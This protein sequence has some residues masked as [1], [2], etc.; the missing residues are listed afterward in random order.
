MASS[1]AKLIAWTVVALL[2]IANLAMAFPFWLDS[3]TRSNRYDKKCTACLPP[4][5]V[6]SHTDTRTATETKTLTPTHSPVGTLTDTPTTTPTF[7]VSPTFTPTPIA[8]SLVVD[9][10]EGLPA[11]D[12]T[13]DNWGYPVAMTCSAGLGSS[14]LAQPSGTSAWVAN[15]ADT[16]GSFG[17]SS[18]AAHVNGTCVGSPTSGQIC[19]LDFNLNPT[20]FSTDTDLTMFTGVSFDFKSDVATTVYNINLISQAQAGTNGYYQFMF[21]ANTTWTTYTVYFPKGTTGYTCGTN[22]FAAPAWAPSAWSGHAGAIRFMPQPLTTSVP[23]G[24]W[25]DNI[26]F[27]NTA[28]PVA[29]A[30]D[31]NQVYM[32]DDCENNPGEDVCTTTAGSGYSGNPNTGYGNGVALNPVSGANWPTGQAVAGGAPVALDPVLGAGGVTN[33]WYKELTGTYPPDPT[34]AP[35]PYGNCNWPL[36]PGGGPYTTLTGIDMSAGQGP[37]NRL[38]FDYKNLGTVDGTNA[39]V[40]YAVQLCTAA[41]TAGPGNPA[42]YN[43]YACLIPASSTWANFV[44]YLPGSAYCGNVFSLVVPTPA[45][46]WSTADV[47]DDVQSVMF[48]FGNNDQTSGHPVDLCIDNLRFD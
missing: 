37:N 20:G 15:S 16:P 34:S 17:T 47:S 28:V 3:P 2:V 48:Y 40:Y 36:V 21:T 27:V 44:V 5:P 1:R 30:L 42:S 19:E 45:Y 6:G 12:E 25:I 11:R 29:P 31:N 23:Y 24:M 35:Y 38:V 9:D 4:P 13:V 33:D 43:F 7:T 14:I 22:V 32:I 39:N 46:P 8:T 10:F 41:T 26:K 18:Y